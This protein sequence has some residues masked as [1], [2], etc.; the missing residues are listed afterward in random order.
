VPLL[1]TLYYTR[2]INRRISSLVNIEPRAG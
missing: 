1:T 2:S